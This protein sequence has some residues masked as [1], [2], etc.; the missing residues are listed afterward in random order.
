MEEEIQTDSGEKQPKWDL[1]TKQ[2]KAY[3]QFVYE[4]RQL[5][6]PYQIR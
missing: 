5:Y 6:Q 4:P 1:L 2:V 3:K